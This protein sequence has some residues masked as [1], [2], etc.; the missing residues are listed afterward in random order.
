MTRAVVRPIRNASVATTASS[1]VG[2]DV[3][4]TFPVDASAE[5]AAGRW[6]LRVRDRRSD[7]TGLLDTWSLQF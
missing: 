4:A 2:D 1:P 6:R 7:N 5:V 3:I